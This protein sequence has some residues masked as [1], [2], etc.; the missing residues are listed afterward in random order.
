MSSLTKPAVASNQAPL[1]ISPLLN[2]IVYS[3]SKTASN[4]S[5]EFASPAVADP[6]AAL[7]RTGTAIVNAAG[8]HYDARDIGVIF[9][10]FAFRYTSW[11][12]VEVLDFEAS[13]MLH[14]CR[15]LD[16]SAQWLD[17]KKKPIRKKT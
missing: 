9:E 10:M 17:L 3:P 7:S 4:A 1:S 2:S 12:P 14:R 11:E 5:Y 16:G 8:L 13:K 6:N 15:M